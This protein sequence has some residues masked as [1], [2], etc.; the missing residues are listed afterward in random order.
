MAWAYRVQGWKEDWAVST[1]VLE[2]PLPSG[3]CALACLWGGFAAAC[4]SGQGPRTAAGGEAMTFDREGPLRPQ[5]PVG[6][7]IHPIHF[8]YTVTE[9]DRHG[10]PASGIA[11]SAV[12]RSPFQL[13][14]RFSHLAASAK[15]EGHEFAVKEWLNL[16]DVGLPFPVAMKV[17]IALAWISSGSSSQD[18]LISPARLTWEVRTPYSPAA[19]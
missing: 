9:G 11:L 14:L 10:G 12:P 19:M 5:R 7:P 16:V 15:C 18:C 13:A 3:L 4:T 2:D 8:M 17:E 1:A 6:Q